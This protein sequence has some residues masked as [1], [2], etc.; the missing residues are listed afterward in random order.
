MQH[1]NP[2]DSDDYVKIAFDTFAN[3]RDGYAFMINAAGA[4]TDSNFGKFA[5]EDRNY[6]AIWTA[7]ARVGAEGWTAEIAIPFKSISFDVK[8]DFWRM[9]IERVIRHAQETDRWSAISRAKQVAAL[10]DFGELRDLR[11]LRQG[12]GLDFRPYVRTTYRNDSVPHTEGFLFDTGFDLTY[13]LTPSLTAVGTV[14]T[15]FAETEVDERIISLSR[16]P[17]F[18]PEKRDFF[19]QDAQ[20]FAFGGLADD[21]RVY[22]SRRIGLGLDFLPVTIFGGLRLTGRVGNTSVALLDVEQ[23]ARNGIEEKNL[24]IARVSQQLTD[25]WNVGLIATN[26]DPSNNGSATLAGADFNF[27]RS[28]PEEKLLIAHGYVLGATSDA[29]GDDVAF[30]ADVDYPNEPLDVHLKFRQ[31]GENFSLP[32]GFLT[33]NDIRTYSGSFTYIWRPNTEWIRSISVQARPLFGTDLGNRIVLEDHDVPFVIVK[34]PALDEIGAGYTFNRDFVDEPFELIPGLIIPPHNYSWSLFQGYIH[35]SEARLVSVKFDLRLGDYY[36][37]TRSD[38]RTEINWRP[39]RFFLIGASYDLREI[40]I[41]AGDFDVRIVAAKMNVAITPDLVWNT[42]VQYDNISRQ[43]GLNSRVRWTWR[44]G[45]DLFFVVNQGWDYD[46]GRLSQS[47]TEITMKIAA[48]F[49]F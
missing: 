21:D 12:L 31:W 7:R 17:T 11:D 43:V 41:P 44:S 33:R 9:N 4:R 28:L 13:R 35:T 2:F 36:G 14:R 34:T 25:E 30:G 37:G 40:R 6:D 19:L 32:L 20:L 27:Q 26:G 24:A 16:F 18:F 47:N 29:V 15:D 38:Y 1:D 5:E 49:R 3:G 42:I 23:A 46:N 8:N 39:S 10:E 22:F 48:A 45:D